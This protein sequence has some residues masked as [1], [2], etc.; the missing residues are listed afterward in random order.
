MRN[1]NSIRAFSLVE[2]LMALLVASL[3]LAALAPVMTKRMNDNVSITGISGGTRLDYKRTFYTD[4]E[5]TVPN[6]VNQINITAIGGGGSGGGAS[7]GFKEI[8]ASESNWIVPDGVTKL[9]VFMTGAGGGGASGG[10]GDT[11]VT[12]NGEDTHKDFLTPGESTFS[13]IVPELDTNCK[14]SGAVN[15]ISTTDSSKAYIPGSSY[16]NSV[17]VTACGGGGGGGGGDPTQGNNGGGGSGGYLTDRTVMFNTNT[18]YIKIPGGG[19][20]GADC[21]DTENASNGGYYSGGGGGGAGRTNT[22][23][24]A[25]GTGG[26]GTGGRGY[27]T[28][29]LTDSLDAGGGLSGSELVYSNGS[30]IMSRGGAG[31]GYAY[32]IT[33]DNN[34]VEYHSGQGGW[35]G[36]WAG[37]GGG[38]GRSAFYKCGGG[39]GGGGGPTTITTQPGT[40][41]DSIVFQVGGGGGGGG[42]GSNIKNVDG[43]SL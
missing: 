16:L 38:G 4:S 42:G 7:Y 3:L 33:N 43:V 34:K 6:G 23:G 37:G 27:Y 36:L 14:T 11:W 18:L 13:K 41:K 25:A 26:S 22:F 9:R 20:G 21:G 40:N 10:R 39:G 19:G 5:W 1:K 30:S 28:L 15:W 17:K 2:M 12:V 31:N 29:S 35:G 32:F 8:T 24:G